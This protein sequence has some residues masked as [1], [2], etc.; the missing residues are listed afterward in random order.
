VIARVIEFVL[1]Q[2]ARQGMRRGVIGGS[3]IWA[4]VWL[5]AFATRKWGLRREAVI[6][7]EKLPPG[8][9][10]RITHEPPAG[11]HEGRRA[12]SR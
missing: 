12:R 2:L 1:G 5:V 11:K 9:A 10:L 3:R 6:Y 7:S 4:I 8:G